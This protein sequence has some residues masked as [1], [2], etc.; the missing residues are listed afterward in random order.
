MGHESQ[1]RKV[2]VT[3]TFNIGRTKKLGL[4]VFVVVWKR[5]DGSWGHWKLRLS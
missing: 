1:R 2:A 4:L 5:R 3:I